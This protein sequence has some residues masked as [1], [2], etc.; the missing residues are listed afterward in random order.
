MRTD[1]L[2]QAIQ[3]K[4]KYLNDIRSV[5]SGNQPQKD[6]TSLKVPTPDISND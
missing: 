2:E 3:Y 5:L 4:D 6:T 1:S